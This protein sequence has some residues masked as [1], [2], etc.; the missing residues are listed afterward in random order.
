MC[1]LS[2]LMMLMVVAM[3]C[4]QF[5][6]HSST[7]LAT[8]LVNWIVP[9][10]LNAVSVMNWHLPS[11]MPDCHEVVGKLFQTRVWAWETVLAEI[12]WQDQLQVWFSC[13]QG[14]AQSVSGVSAFCKIAYHGTTLC[15]K[16]CT[17]F[18]TL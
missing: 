11:L 8:S 13:I 10:Y 5:W 18:E 1:E 12:N 9:R 14:F 7:F 4:T 3:Q 6:V 17:N 15:L 2:A 16:K